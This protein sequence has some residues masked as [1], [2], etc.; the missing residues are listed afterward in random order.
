MVCKLK[1]L[2]KQ[3][4]FILIFALLLS[5]TEGE[6]SVLVQLRVLTGFSLKKF[7][8]KRSILVPRESSFYCK[9]ICKV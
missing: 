4:F 5:W 7:L 9:Q 2:S 3:E 8:K 1:P 6:Y